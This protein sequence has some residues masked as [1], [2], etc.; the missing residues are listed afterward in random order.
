M[1]FWRI[2]VSSWGVAWFRG[3]KAQAEAW[4]RHKANWERSVAR[5]HEVNESDIP[6]GVVVRDL[7]SELG[8]LT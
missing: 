7:S 4:R 3:T 6:E 1:K 5:K 8:A 2:E